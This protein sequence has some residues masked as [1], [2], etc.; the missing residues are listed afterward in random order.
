M[1]GIT[2]FLTEG[3]F[4]D[5]D[6]IKALEASSD[7]L[8]HRGPDDFG[9]WMQETDGIFLGHRRLAILDLSSAGHQPMVSR[10]NR[11][12]LVLNG[13]IYNHLELRKE[14]NGAV[15]WKGHSDT[16]TLIQCIE[17]WG[18]EKTLEK[19]R[20][21]FAFGLWDKKEKSLTLARD[22][23]GEK[24][25]YYGWQNGT[26]FFGS[27]LKAIKNNPLFRAEINRDS[28]NLFLQ[29]SYVPSPYSIYR[30]IYKLKPGSY[31]KVS[32]VSRESSPLVYWS[33]AEKVKHNFQKPFGGTREEAIERL[34]VLL[35]DSVRGQMMSDV[36]LGALL[37]GGID[38]S[39]VVAIMQKISQRPIQTFTIGFEDKIFD[40]AGYAAQVAGFLG[41]AH[42]EMY[43]KEKDAMNV[44]PEMPVLY[45]EP[46]ADVSQIPTYLVARLARNKVAVALTGDGG[47]E[48][49]GGYTRYS[50]TQQYWRYISQWPVWMRSSVSSF[51]DKIPTNAWKKL[52]NVGGF[53]K[54]L[55]VLDS[56]TIEELYRRLVG[57]EELAFKL[58]NGS[59][60]TVELPQKL[61]DLDE[62][63]KM[64]AIDLMTFLPD[65]ILVKVD[66]A[67]MGV[68]LETRVPFLDERIMEFAWSLPLDYKLYRGKNKWILRQVLKRY[69][70]E[71]LIDRPKMGFGV[72]IDQW[73]RSELRE[74]AEELLDKG[75][76]GS[77][78]Y[79][80]PYEV[81]KIWNIHLS[82]KRNCGQSLWKILMFQAWLS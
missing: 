77:E 64:M 35:T 36:P 8:R 52:G 24:P 46:F 38:S 28:L 62:V 4:P 44:I 20:G 63:S 67:S 61:N 30:D 12:V 45:D 69:I 5:L 7:T 59:S 18:I 72:P 43:V 37:S 68:S 78:G 1:C 53:R 19:I 48:L 11:F 80:N 79:F 2:G 6:L 39:L 66:R 15:V 50:W 55:K 34:E 56:K 82:G 26:F 41:T 21:M 58:M 40:E 3:N 60:S 29:L 13:E 33:S 70:P 54:A 22:R 16:E 14:L 10:E 76:L 73:L 42:S 32:L 47:D 75:K 71:E 23:F 81:H 17:V 49:F 31:L 74:W 27:E 57:D 25:L 65:D 9:H 51:L